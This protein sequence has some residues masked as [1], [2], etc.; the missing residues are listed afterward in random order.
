MKLVIVTACLAGV[1]HS[2][3]V[4]AALKKEAEAR[5]HQVWCE[6]QGG[7]NLTESL[8]AAVCR[9]ADVVIVAYAIAVAGQERFA[10]KPI[11]KVPIE[12]A[13]R[14][15]KPLVDKAEEVFETMKEQRK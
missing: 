14:N 2:K 5:G 1:A 11:I 4:A 8:P 12:K 7:Y 6:M 15:I 13:I 3:M 10:G 9:Q